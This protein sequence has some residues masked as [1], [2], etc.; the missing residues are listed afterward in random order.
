M[1]LS[2]NSKLVL[3]VTP[4]A[5]AAGTDAIN[6][7]VIDTQ[8]FRGVMFVVAM[9][10]IVTGAATSIKVQQGT[11]S[12]VTDA[13]DIAGTSQTIA[14]TAGGKVFYS[15]IKN[16]A[17]RYLRL[18]VSRATQNATVASAIAILYDPTDAPTTHGAG[19]SGES[20]VGPAEGTA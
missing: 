14:D 18:V 1:Q 12:T 16:P 8:G 2:K 15:D 17:E 5:G 20:L 7:T 3:V 9:G 19:V 11:D 10:A 13:A 4:T 6:G